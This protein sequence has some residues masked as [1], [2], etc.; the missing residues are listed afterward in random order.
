MV[1]NREMRIFACMATSLDGKIGPAGIDH[2][3]AIGSRYD[4]ENLITIRDEAD[5]ILVG[6]STFRTW[7]KVHRG[8][9]PKRIAHHFIMSRSL[10]LDFEADL[11]QYP[12]IPVTIFSGSA[13]TERPEATP[14]HVQIVA[15]PDQA[16]QIQSILSYISGCG[17][18]AL[19]IE[20]GGHILNQF[21]STEAL[22]ELYLTLVPVVIG[23]D[24]A[25][26]LLGGQP[27]KSAP[28]LSV[29][30]S[31][32]VGNEVFLHLDLHYK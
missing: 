14:D 3:V 30:N 8:N 15:I 32:L 24:L 7:P 5:G 1:E 25:P 20:G 17:V 31:R 22:Q 27:L 9:D 18:T 6:A 10:D 28:K 12:D 11:F 26:A 21:I 19:L 29:R 13:R 2:F 16:D 4:M 23:D